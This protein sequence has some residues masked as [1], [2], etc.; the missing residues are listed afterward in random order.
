MTADME[1]YLSFIDAKKRGNKFFSCYQ[2]DQLVAW[3]S[4]EILDVNKIELGLGM[5]PE[6]T[7]KGF[8]VDFIN[9][10]MDHICSKYCTKEFVLSVASFNKRAIKVYEKVGFTKTGVFIQN[11]NGGDYEFIKMSLLR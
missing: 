2:N 3:Y 8:G 4:I 11:T 10:A 1:D 7:G 5:K 9:S 6:H